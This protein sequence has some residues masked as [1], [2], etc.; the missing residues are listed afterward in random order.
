MG[1]P[2]FRNIGHTIDTGDAPPVSKPSYRLNPME[3]DEVTRQVSDLLAWGLFRP[4][5]SSSGSPVLFVQEKDG[6]L[7]MCIAY[8]ALNAVTAKDKYPLPRIDDLL[9]RLHGAKVFSSL[10]L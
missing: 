2:P 3:K 4:S 9:V 5:Q 10:D 6:S 7:R 8:R 1:L